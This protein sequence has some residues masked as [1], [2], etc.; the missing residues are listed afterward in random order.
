MN[1][2]LPGLIETDIVS[3]TGPASAEAMGLPTYD[4]MLELFTQE[5]AIKRCNTVEEVGA[6]A[7][8]LA[9]DAARNMTG[10]MFPI[11]GGTMPY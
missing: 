8:L 4:S 1:S 9:C 11:D 10:C 5:S 6:V 7:V 3:A 2:F